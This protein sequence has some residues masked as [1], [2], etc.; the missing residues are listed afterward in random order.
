M[1]P[2][3]QKIP[4]NEYISL[5]MAADGRVIEFSGRKLYATRTEVSLL[6]PLYASPGGT[7][8]FGTIVTLKRL[9]K[10]KDANGKEVES[11]KTHCRQL[12]YTNVSRLRH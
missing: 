4:D 11:F 10:L 9:G 8:V 6:T 1:K 5:S 12:F 7:T 2:E 3:L